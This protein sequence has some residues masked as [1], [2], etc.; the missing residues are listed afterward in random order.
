VIIT[1][2]IDR[3]SV[4]AVGGEVRLNLF[5]ASALRAD[6]IYAELVALE[7]L[8]VVR[9]RP[10]DLAVSCANR[11]W[12]SLDSA[13][14][15]ARTVKETYV[16]AA[17]E[18]DVAV[19]AMPSDPGRASER[20]D[21]E[22]SVDQVTAWC[23]AP[24]EEDLKTRKRWAVE[25]IKADQAWLFAA[26]RGLPRAGENIVIAQPDTGIT[27]HIELSGVPLWRPLNVLGGYPPDDPTDPM[28]EEGNPGHGT[29]TSSVMVSRET[30]EVIGSGPAATLMPI[31]AIERVA[32]PRMTKVADAV[33]H[34]VASGAHIVSMSLGGI[35]SYSLW[36]AIERAVAADLIVMAAAGNC[37]GI[38]VWPA[39]FEACIGVAGVD[40]HFMPW[41]GSSRGPGVDIAAPA[42]NVY[43]ANALT[44]DVGQGQ[45]T[46]FAVALT[47]GAAACWL[48]FHGRGAMI[49]AARQRGESLQDMFRR[50]VRATAQR[51]AGWEEM[52]MGAGVVDVDAL[53]K[54]DFDLGR[55]TEGPVRPNLP[56]DPGRSLRSL[57][58]ERLAVGEFDPAIDW[59]GHG[60]E[61][62]LQL[63]RGEASL[64]TLPRG[65]SSPA[66]LER[67][68]AVPPGRIRQLRDQIAAGQEMAG[69]AGLERLRV[70][71]SAGADPLTE[72]AARE[73]M[74]RVA[75]KVEQQTRARADS[76]TD[77]RQRIAG[78]LAML[79]EHGTAALRKLVGVRDPDAAPLTT[80]E[81]ASL[82]AIVIADGTRPSFLIKGGAPP[83]NDPF[84]GPWGGLI[85]PL[86]NEIEQ[87][88]AAIGR[89]QP[90]NGHNGYFVGTGS[91]V[92]AGK[93]LI[94]TN[95]H[96]FDDA[97]NKFLIPAQRVNAT[98]FRI[99]ANL[100]IDFVGEGESL[101]V[102]RFR[103]VEANLDPRS[104]RGFG[105]LDAVTMR[106][107]PINQASVLPAPIKFSPDVIDFNKASDRDLCTIGFPGRPPLQQ[108]PKGEV[109]WDFVLKTLFGDLFGVKRLAPGRI[110]RRPGAVDRDSLG[111][112]F[113]H[114]ATTFQGA[115]GSP[116]FAWEVGGQ[117]A[118][119]LHF[120][121]DV[122]V[123]NYAMAS[124]VV[125]PQFR[126]LGVP[127]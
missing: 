69:G 4:P 67:S 62:S 15:A 103:I 16:L 105:R 116:V 56:S 43:R 61:I 3:N 91:L 42:Q 49:A 112:V 107:E 85:G 26:S 34:A 37:V 96:V 122:E 8:A 83:L 106:I 121:G 29:G 95:F 63:I 52:T 76:G 119:G 99:L 102:N 108:G 110:I 114:D 125:A 20:Q 101:T 109:N 45:G 6:T 18:A 104:G 17:C 97:I 31:R 30:Y 64:E 41:R 32:E 66:V 28:N 14:Q 124:A 53:I 44:R 38:V 93:G 22:E 55:E 35:W 68:S 25:A 115:S 88:T 7:G 65:I 12:Q 74:E 98:Q 118:I 21:R 24:E 2:I 77:D 120:A 36:A 59:I 23:W 54:A 75:G 78:A 46:S 60:E 111:T 127:L 40:Q 71:E 80:N 19:P 39:R 5:V 13:F 70:L 94:L 9:M 82:E 117:P 84:M 79:R 123:S 1:E 92:N 11:A 90:K 89:I 50:L 51:P 58:V 86:Q 47:A 10:L 33:D 27:S 72:A 48:A 87:L 81:R 100:E 73:V 57:A 126:A 113:G